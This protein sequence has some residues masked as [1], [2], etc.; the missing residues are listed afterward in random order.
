MRWV[1]KVTYIQYLTLKDEKRE[2]IDT[3]GKFVKASPTIYFKKKRYEPMYI[4]L[5]H[6]PLKL[7]IEGGQT[8]KNSEVIN[9]SSPFW[10]IEKFYRG[11]PKS[12]MIRLKFL[13]ICALMR[14]IEKELKALRELEGSIFE[15]GDPIAQN[16]LSKFGNYNL[17]NALSGNDI[18]KENEVLELP[19][20]QCLQW[21]SMQSAQNK[22]QKQYQKRQE[23]RLKNK[24]K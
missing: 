15:K 22:I 21:V 12:K 6:M 3:I 11:I 14:W 4:P 16:I 7:L 20:I 18:L 9:I 17:I 24:R 10:C 5:S 2:E 19:Y 13:N 1:E 8:I 23:Q